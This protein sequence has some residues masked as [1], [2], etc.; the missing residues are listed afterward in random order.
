MWL[1]EA[2]WTEVAKSYPS[3]FCSLP[4]ASTFG[5]QVLHVQAAPGHADLSSS[6]TV[7]NQIWRDSTEVLTYPSRN[8]KSSD[9][10]RAHHECANQHGKELGS[11]TR[12]WSQSG[13]RSSSGKAMGEVILAVETNCSIMS[14]T[15]YVLW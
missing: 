13:S 3:G 12:L 4:T 7:C 10:Q 5:R 1:S 2:A 9:C 14:I 15:T 11:D 6:G 8:A